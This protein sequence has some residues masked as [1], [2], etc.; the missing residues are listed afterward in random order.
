MPKIKGT[1]GNATSVI[2]EDLYP[3]VANK[4]KT[5]TPQYKR[6]VQ[7]F[8]N[9]N[10]KNIQDIAPYYNIY[11]TASDVKAF[12]NSIDIKEEDVS[13]IMENCFYWNISYNPGAAKEPLVVTSMC[14]I[15]YF[16]E[17]KKRMEAELATIY[18]C[19]S[20]KFYASVYSSKGVFPKVSPGIRY[21]AVMDYVVNNML[22]QQSYLK[23]KGSIFGSVRAIASTYLDAYQDD[24]LSDLDDDEIGKLIQQL[25]DRL[26]AFLHEIA[27]KFYEAK[28]GNYY[29]TTDHENLDTNIGD[30]KLTENDSNKAAR[31]TEVALNYMLN[32]TANMAICDQASQFT[33]TN[34]GRRD[35]TIVKPTEIKS[36]IEAVT[37]NKDNINDLRTVINILICDYL[38]TYPKGKINSVDF[39]TFSLKGKPNS[40]DKYV[41]EMRAIIKNWIVEGSDNYRRRKSTAGTDNAYY[42]AV[43][44]Y[45][46]FT[47]SVVAKNE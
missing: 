13:K 3:V 25:R 11:H 30:F 46:V 4:L 33:K 15:R 38:R 6:M 8:M 44:Y 27:T 2:Y 36:I 14:I 26:K 1:F 16:L 32:N 22:T 34:N 39:L 18:L 23:S 10:S 35:V 29:I 19:F 45:I 42:K 21:K 17:N 24:L 12:F 28:E 37:E 40:R 41:L 9:K 43:L 7:E 20:G 5:R 47:I 31:V